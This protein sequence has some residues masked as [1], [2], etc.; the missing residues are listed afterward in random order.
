METNVAQLD[1]DKMKCKKIH[2][3]G[4]FCLLLSSSQVIFS[5]RFHIPLLFAWRMRYPLH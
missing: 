5:H 3:D 2:I 4:N 1:V